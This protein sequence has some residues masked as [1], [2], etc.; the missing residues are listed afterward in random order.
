[1]GPPQHQWPELDRAAKVAHKPPQTV[2][3]PRRTQGSIPDSGESRAQL[4]HHQGWGLTV[5][6]LQDLVV[7]GR[8]HANGLARKVGVEVE[9]FS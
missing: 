5:I 7:D 8:G 6:K 9:A 4:A 2:P 1:M 3:Q